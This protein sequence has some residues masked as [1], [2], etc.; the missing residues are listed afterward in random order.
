LP[1]AEASA[2]ECGH[3]DSEK[4][5]KR[6]L[7]CFF[8]ATE[9][10]NPSDREA[11]REEG[12]L[13]NQIHFVRRPLY[14]QVRDTFAMWIVT[15]EWRPGHAVSNEVELAQGLG[16]STG[17][18]RKALE[19]LENEHLI[20]RHQGRGT[21]V[22][23]R[24]S[25]EMSLRFSNLRDVNGQRL[26][27]EVASSEATNGIATEVECAV[28][29]VR[30]TETVMR[31]RQIRQHKKRPLL[32]ENTVIPARLFPRPPKEPSARGISVMAHENGLLLG[33]ATEKVSIA[34]GN[35]EAAA[36]LGLPPEQPLLKLD[37]LI[38]TLD[39]VPVE[40]RVALCHLVDASYVSEIA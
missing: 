21:F 20:V 35:A 15:G 9:H 3:I 34:H 32:V 12:S 28:L 22:T 14:L 2:L 37:R 10:R 39:G 11:Q 1:K 8:G 25:D 7:V 4:I 33:R 24:T 26:D 36:A 27:G 31:T 17:T 18:V 13:V 40:W 19:A 29:Q 5:F 6:W 23:D 30:P 16:V 38:F